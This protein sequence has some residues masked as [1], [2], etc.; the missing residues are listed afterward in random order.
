MS[1]IK[2]ISSLSI[3]LV[4]V[5]HILLYVERANQLKI[6][7]YK[8]VFIMKTRTLYIKMS[9]SLNKRGTQRVIMVRVHGLMMARCH[10]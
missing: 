1:E 8:E 6:I 3:Q 5:M 10:Q 7:N 2:G 4:I 9:T